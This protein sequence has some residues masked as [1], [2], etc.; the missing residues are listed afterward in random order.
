MKHIDVIFANEVSDDAAETLYGEIEARIGSTTHYDEAWTVLYGAKWAI[1]G[2]RIIDPSKRE[3][4]FA[5]L[6]CCFETEES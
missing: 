2:I 1:T 4:I 5:A 3:A 6:D